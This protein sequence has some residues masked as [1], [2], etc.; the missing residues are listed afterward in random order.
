MS[1]GKVLGVSFMTFAL[2]FLVVVIGAAGIF[3]YY[4]PAASAGGVGQAAADA[5]LAVT[6]L[7]KTTDDA[8][9]YEKTGVPT[10]KL[11]QQADEL[12]EQLT[13]T[14]TDALKDT[15]NV[16]SITIG[17]TKTPGAPN[18]PTSPVT[19]NNYNNTYYGSRDNKDNTQAN[20]TD[21]V[22]TQEAD[23]DTNDT[24][25]ARM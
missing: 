2:V 13:H 5:N 22:A 1:S 17:V 4:H 23:N 10:D 11:H 15:G 6:P 12:P 20:L 18:I 16:T 24:R 25:T 8:N 14:A 9:T 21:T 7:A 3:M 19:N